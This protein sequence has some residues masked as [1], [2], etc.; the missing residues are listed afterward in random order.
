M[1]S[2]K[3]FGTRSSDAMASVESDGQSCVFFGGGREVLLG[4]DSLGLVMAPLGLAY[5]RLCE[6]VLCGVLL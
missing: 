2:W 5:H 6:A 4:L 1:R 3:G